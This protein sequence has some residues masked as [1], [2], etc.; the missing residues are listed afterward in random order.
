QTDKAD[1]YCANFRARFPTDARALRC[2]LYALTAPRQTPTSNNDITAAWKLAD[3]LAVLE[4]PPTRER[5]RLIGRM[6]VA[7]TIARA[8]KTTPALADS[9]RK[10]AHRSEGSVQMDATREL[11]FRGAFVYTLLGDHD[12]AI[13]LLKDYFAANPNRASSLANDP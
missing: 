7:A 3:S 2:Q 12:D 1:Q 13:R 8:S 4:P 9:A 5:E 11:A 10:L 6:L